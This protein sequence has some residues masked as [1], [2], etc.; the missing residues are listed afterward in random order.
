[1]LNIFE[2][3]SSSRRPLTQE[4]IVSAVPG[5]NGNEN[6]RRQAFERTKSS[7]KAAGVP[8]KTVQTGEKSV[9]RYTIDPEDLYLQLDLTMEERDALAFALGCVEVAPDVLSDISSRMGFLVDQSPF[10][11]SGLSVD[12]RIARLSEA[13]AQRITVAF[14]YNA[15]RRRVNTLKLLQRWG[16]WYL[17]GADIDI[18]ELRTFRIDRIES[19]VELLIG[20]AFARPEDLPIEAFFSQPSQKGVD[21]VVVVAD[22]FGGSMLR[23]E[24]DFVE[25]QKVEEGRFEYRSVEIRDIDHLVMQ[26]VGL[27]GHIEVVSPPQVIDAL[28]EYVRHSSVFEPPTWDPEEFE[29]SGPVAQRPEEMSA[30]PAKVANISSKEALRKFELLQRVLPYFGRTGS[31]SLSQA[32]TRFGVSMG[33]LAALLETAACCGLPP[34]DPGTLLT[35]LVDVDEDVVEVELDSKLAARRRI[36]YSEAIVLLGAGKTLLKAGVS[37]SAALSSA[38]EKLE[39]AVAH[40]LGDLHEIEFDI[41]VPA[42]LDLVREAVSEGTVLE[43]NYHS[44]SSEK[45]TV[46]RIEPLRLFLFGSDWYVD[47]YCRNEHRPLTFKL[48]RMTGARVVEVPLEN[49]DRSRILSRN[50]G[51]FD[52]EGDL[53]EVEL[54]LDRGAFRRLEVVLPQLFE[55]LQVRG[56]VRL[57]RVVATSSAWLGRLLL[58]LGSGVRVGDGHDEAVDDARSLGLGVL[59]LYGTQLVQ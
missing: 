28:V 39:R 17:L 12:T 24:L 11:L 56:D 33:E 6:S 3:L 58:Q 23:S 45:T 29:I 41:P 4:E 43:I 1:M 37:Q 2:L 9:V 47:A 13:A 34:Y 5:F 27:S 49:P 54:W 53:D 10:R 55:Q 44:R 35:I 32:S 46:R 25:V 30:T 51:V 52:F 31:Y 18:G 50:D 59:E 48:S 26:L 15:R 14:T 16:H 42:C 7:L 22:E 8:V 36:D 21:P 19:A 57:V 20:S 38:I 40:Y